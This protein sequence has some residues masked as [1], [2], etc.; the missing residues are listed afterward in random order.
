[1]MPPSTKIVVPVVARASAARN[2]AA[3]PQS[4]G[5]GR[6]GVLTSWRP[7]SKTGGPQPAKSVSTSPGAIAL[8][9]ITGPSARAS[10]RVMDPSAA[11]D[12]AYA[13]DE[14][15]P[16]NAAT[17]VMLMITPRPWARMTGTAVLV[18]YQGAIPFVSRTLRQI[19]S[20][21]AS[22]SEWDTG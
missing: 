21:R 15:L 20:V 19:S 11:F 4:S 2:S 9:R 5:V 1:M 10:D 6:S 8:T 13:S 14:P 16:L 17:E 18:Q 22:R 3:S 7:A 12:A